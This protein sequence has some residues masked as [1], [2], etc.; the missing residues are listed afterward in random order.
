VEDGGCG[1]EHGEVITWV[2]VSMVVER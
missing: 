1:D 2:F